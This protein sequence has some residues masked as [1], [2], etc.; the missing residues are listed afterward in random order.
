MQNVFTAISKSLDYLGHT[1]LTNIPAK[2]GEKFD[3]NHK[4]KLLMWLCRYWEKPIIFLHGDEDIHF[5]AKNSKL[6]AFFGPKFG[7]YEGK[8]A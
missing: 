5:S 1:K 3:L 7:S 4:A 8:L 2:V 6:Y